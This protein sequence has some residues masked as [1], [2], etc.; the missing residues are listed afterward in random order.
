M[1]D[2][3][4]KSFI[5]TLIEAEEKSKTYLLPLTVNEWQALRSENNRAYQAVALEVKVRH[6]NYF[7]D[8]YHAGYDPKFTLSEEEVKKYNTSINDIDEFEKSQLQLQP[9]ENDLQQRNVPTTV[10]LNLIARIAKAAII[11]K[12]EKIDAEVIVDVKRAYKNNIYVIEGVALVPIEGEVPEYRGLERSLRD[13]HKAL[14]DD[15]QPGESK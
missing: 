8:S 10:A 15:Q 2:D 9:G 3:K 11:S 12:A 7:R 6:S 5:D 4:K 1:S 14:V 13:I